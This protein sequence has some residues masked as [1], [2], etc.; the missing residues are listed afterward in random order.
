MDGSEINGCADEP[1]ISTLISA[2]ISKKIHKFVFPTTFPLKR[3]RWI[4]YKRVQDVV[5]ALGLLA[6]LC[7]PLLC[8]A[9]WIKWDSPGPIIFR[10]PR[11]G[12]NST[13]FSCYKFRTMY[14]MFADPDART[15]SGR[16]DPRVTRVGVILRR[17]SI[18]ELPQLFN[19][20]LGDMSLVG[21]RPHATATSIDGFLLADLADDYLLRY[22]VKPGITGWAQVNGWRGILDCEEKLQKRLE[23][24]FYYISNWTPLLDLK[25]LYRTLFCIIDRNAF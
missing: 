7:I 3:K 5:L 25:I 1:Q 14:H 18:D 11:R 17:M 9:L 2:R 16:N 24:D 15:Q 23:Y 4:I 13:Y 10:Q 22:G 12:L 21:P 19:V 8:I 6:F 20:L